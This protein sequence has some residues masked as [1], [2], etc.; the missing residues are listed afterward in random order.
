MT[1]FPKNNSATLKS[2]KAA[3]DDRERAIYAFIDAVNATEPR[4]DDEHG[5]DR[6]CGDQLQD[7]IDADVAW[8]AACERL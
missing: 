8:K 2:I 5:D 6:I 1:K 4:D 3:W 7:L